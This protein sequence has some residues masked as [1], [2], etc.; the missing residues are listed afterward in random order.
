MEELKNIREIMLTLISFGTV[1]GFIIDVSRKFFIETIKFKYKSIPGKQSR[2]EIIVM[3]GV[4]CS[5]SINVIFSFGEIIKL[6]SFKRKSADVTLSKEVIL[7]LIFL[8]IWGVYEWLSGMIFFEVRELFI[9]YIENA[10]VR[11]CDKN[12]LKKCTKRV[13]CLILIAAT[14]LG[15]SIISIDET[16]WLKT[17]WFGFSLFGVTAI[18]TFTI[19]FSIKAI[20]DEMELEKTYVLYANHNTNI[21]CKC[22]LE[23]DDYLLVFNNGVETYILKSDVKVKTILKDNDRI[24]SNIC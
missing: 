20:L 3:M 6:I 22:Y 16:Q 7:I 4:I 1:A 2:F 19:L 14:Y 9:Y 18:I 24:K 17:G 15:V 12:V 5:I 13:K 11:N 21:C 10:Q 8:T 23:Y